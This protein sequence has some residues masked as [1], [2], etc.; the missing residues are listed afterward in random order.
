MIP[1]NPQDA[2]STAE[3][4]LHRVTE[5]VTKNL[6][7]V[8]RGKHSHSFCPDAATTLNKQHFRILS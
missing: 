1:G 2:T 4:D 8:L 7:L 6:G 5:L 3:L